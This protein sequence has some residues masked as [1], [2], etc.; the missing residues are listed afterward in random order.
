MLQK[1]INKVFSNPTI[2]IQVRRVLENNFKGEKEVI[3]REL[4]LEGTTLDIACGTG[5]FCQFFKKEKYLGVDLSE[6]YIEYAKKKYGYNFQVM[7]ATKMKVE[8]KFDNILVCGVFHHLNDEAVLTILH[9][10]KSLIRDDGRILVMEDMPT[11]S[12]MNVIG[13]VVQHFDV[14]KFIRKHE[15]YGELY[16]KE[17]K[18]VKE[19]RMRSGVND[20]SV[21]VLEK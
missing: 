8:E 17:L 18:V 15:A 10:A 21:Y 4:N 13:K 6:K 16:K 12:K 1:V 19:H 20:Y 14:G 5:E 2:F 7:D 3:Q 11:V 9:S